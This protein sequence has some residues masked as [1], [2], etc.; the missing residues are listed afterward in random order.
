MNTLFHLKALLLMATCCFVLSTNNLQGQSLSFDETLQYLN[1]KLPFLSTYDPFVSANKDG[2]VIIDFL[3]SGITF[4]FN[5]FEVVFEEE[6]T[7]NRVRIRIKCKDTFKCM[8][9]TSDTSTNHMTLNISIFRKSEAK[10]IINA[11]N[12][13][14]EQC[15]KESDPFDY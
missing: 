3:K 15:T 14:R 10:K 5:L 7:I 13:L 8:T 2:D 1:N 12:H 11:F 4:H 6:V 9:R